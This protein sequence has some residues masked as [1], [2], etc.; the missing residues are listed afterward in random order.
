MRHA[1]VAVDGDRCAP[2]AG[3]HGLAQQAL[4]MATCTMAVV[5][6]PTRWTRRIPSAARKMAGKAAGVKPLWPCAALLAA[7]SNGRGCFGDPANGPSSCGNVAS[8][9]V[10]RL[11]RETVRASGWSAAIAVYRNHRTPRS[12]SGAFFAYFLCTS[13]ESESAAGPKPPPPVRAPCRQTNRAAHGA[14]GKRSRHA[15]TLTPTFSNKWARD[16]GH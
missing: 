11:L 2:A 6:R 8:G 1:V 14:R 9:D 13:K 15:T 16:Q 12:Y 10:E 3:A 7:P 4:D 5:P